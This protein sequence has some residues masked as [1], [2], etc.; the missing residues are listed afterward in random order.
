MKNFSLYNDRASSRVS[1]G[2]LPT[3]V[4]SCE[5]KER[6]IGMVVNRK[7]KARTVLVS[8][9]TAHPESS[10]QV[11]SSFRSSNEGRT[12]AT[13]RNHRQ[14]TNTTQQSRYERTPRHRTLWT[15]Y[16]NFH[17][18]DGRRKATRPD[19][20][21]AHCALQPPPVR[22]LYASR[23]IME[24]AKGYRQP[25]PQTLQRPGCYAKGVLKRGIRRGGALRKR[26]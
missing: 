7:G 8:G 9:K 14:I 16:T 12:S 6:Y 5:R 2:S 26:I 24:K 25:C 17:C 21:E 20:E 23:P 11:H 4:A 18:E 22:S 1:R 10:C 15:T 13:R 3:M 19:R